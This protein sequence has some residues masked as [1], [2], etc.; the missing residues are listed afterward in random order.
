MT[1]STPLAATRFRHN[2]GDNVRVPKLSRLLDHVVDLENAPDRIELS[3]FVEGSPAA[4]ARLMRFASKRDLLLVSSLTILD[5]ED[6]ASATSIF[7]LKKEG[8]TVG[9]INVAAGATS[10]IV[11]ITDPALP[12]GAVL[13][14]FAPS[15]QDAT[16]ADVSI[17][18]GASR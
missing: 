9:T 8:V 4:G 2:E 15:V 13:Q 5:A 16:L 12:A 6:A 10:G 3:V 1:D 14:L 18:I 17:S 11:S 7:T